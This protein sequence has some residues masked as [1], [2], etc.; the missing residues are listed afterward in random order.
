MS[1]TLQIVGALLVLA[2]FT[3]TQ[4]G[5]VTPT[6]IAYL[7]VNLV[8]SGLLAVLALIGRDWGFLLLEGVWAL[9]SLISLIRVLTRPPRPRPNAGRPTPPPAR[10]V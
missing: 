1:T 5:W 6:S 10:P 8:G 3:G 9:V 7:L 2:G 4:L